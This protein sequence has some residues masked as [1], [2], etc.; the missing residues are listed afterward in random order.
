MELY[1]DNKKDKNPLST[2]IS[3]N[4]IEIRNLTTSY[5]GH[6]AL[7]NINLN[8]KEKEY[9]CL[10]G[11]NGSGKSTLIKCILGL[12]KPQEGTVRITERIGDKKHGFRRFHKTNSRN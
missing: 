9:V 8:I 7:K 4:V 5:N 3:K 2:E 6:I 11:D 10:V 12:N 1:E